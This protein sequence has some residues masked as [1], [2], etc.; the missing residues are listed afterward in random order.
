MCQ[1]DELV[2]VKRCLLSNTTCEPQASNHHIVGP[3]QPNG[4]RRIASRTGFA[5]CFFA[6]LCCGFF[7]LTGCDDS[8]ANASRNLDEAT[9]TVGGAELVA[10]GIAAGADLTIVTLVS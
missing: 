4:A 6:N 5:A 8:S 2:R 1:G 7:G 9:A 3:N 10:S